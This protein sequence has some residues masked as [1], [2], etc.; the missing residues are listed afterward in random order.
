VWRSQNKAAWLGTAV[1]AA[2][3]V[4]YSTAGFFTRLVETDAWTM[5]FWRGLFAGLFLSG[6]VVWRERGHVAQSVRAIGRDGLLIGVFSALATVCFLNGLRLSSVA[7]VMVI[8]AMMPFC[9]A[10]IAWLLIGE[11]EDRITLAATFAAV[12]G[13]AVMAGP[14][15]AGGRLL[16]DLLTFAM[17]LLMSSVLV[18]IRRH[19]GV[20][21]LPAVALSAFLCALFVLPWARPLSVGG[22]DLIRLLLFG[23]TQFGMGLLLL[24]A[25]TPLVSATRGAL[26]GTLQTPLAT[27]WVWLVFSETPATATLIG[28]AIVLAAVV[29]D[30]VVPRTRQAIIHAEG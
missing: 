27:F 13:V 25:G 20:S 22:D 30:V 8:D 1:L 10:G 2:S 4:C 17:V 28:G 15:I 26:I 3:A 24:S 14:A 9:T 23:T 12:A 7:D 11:R 16:G 18:L 29:A 21:M 6:M 19:P 5:L